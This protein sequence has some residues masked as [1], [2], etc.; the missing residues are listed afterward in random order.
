MT[1]TISSVLLGAGLLAG[2]TAM[3]SSQA[4]EGHEGH[5]HGPTEVVP[6]QVAPNE[7]SPDIVTT[8]P[9]FETLENAPA[10]SRSLPNP[11]YERE[12]APSTRDWG[13]TIEPPITPRREFDDRRRLQTA[14]RAFDEYPRD[15]QTRPR[16]YND[17]RPPESPLQGCE[18]GCSLDAANVDRYGN[19]LL[20]SD[21]WS[22][23][24][25]SGCGLSVEPQ[26]YRYSDELDCHAYERFGDVDGFSCSYGEPY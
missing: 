3:P 14:P 7:K 11:S 12:P 10:D 2:V 8:P 23:P 1:R 18:I 15:R 24:Q 5:D 6:P 20:H 26:V 21:T 19:R 13:Q 25:P 4:H 9:P 16:K 22:R 17:V